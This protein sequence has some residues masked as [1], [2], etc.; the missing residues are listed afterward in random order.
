VLDFG[1]VGQ[2]GSPCVMRGF[3]ELFGL[4]QAFEE[5]LDVGITANPPRRDSIFGTPISDNARE[6]DEIR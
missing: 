2:A 5:I 1:A 6:L 4:F 3:G